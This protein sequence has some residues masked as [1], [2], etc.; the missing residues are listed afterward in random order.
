MDKNAKHAHPQDMGPSTAEAVSEEAA[1]S[2]DVPPRK[3]RDGVPLFNSSVG[4]NLID[5]PVD[6]TSDQ[7]PTEQSAPPT[8]QSITRP[9]S[10]E[11]LPE[12]ILANEQKERQRLIFL[13]NAI[14]LRKRHYA[15]LAGAQK[16]ATYIRQCTDWGHPIDWAPWLQAI[17]H[18][19]PPMDFPK[20]DPSSYQQLEAPGSGLGGLIAKAQSKRASLLSLDG[21]VVARIMG[22]LDYPSLQNLRM[23]AKKFDDVYDEWWEGVCDRVYKQKVHK[24][25]YIT[26]FFVPPGSPE[27]DSEDK[28]R[29]HHYCIDWIVESILPDY[30][31]ARTV[32]DAT[33]VQQSIEIF[34][35]RP[36]HQLLKSGNKS[37]AM[38]NERRIPFHKG[39]ARSRSVIVGDQD[40]YA[41]ISESEESV[42][43]RKS[44]SV[45]TNGKS[46]ADGAK[47]GVFGSV[48]PQITEGETFPFPGL[49]KYVFEKHLGSPRRSRDN[50]LRY[51]KCLSSIE[52]MGLRDATD[53]R[54][55]FQWGMS[56]VAWY[57]KKNRTVYYAVRNEFLK[58]FKTQSGGDVEGQATRE[59]E[60]TEETTISDQQYV[61]RLEWLRPAQ[62][63][64]LVRLVDLKA[65]NL[66]TAMRVR[67]FLGVCEDGVDEVEV[68]EEFLLRRVAQV[69]GA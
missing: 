40:K 54:K 21:D 45:D 62:L 55:A 30:C 52:K 44:R 56:L 18:A 64:E 27:E 6:H 33:T 15:C 37:G 60:G 25:S 13:R 19:Q 38:E 58:H 24:I 11:L 12:E 51:H 16:I 47:Q 10:A 66:I 46:K 8:P 17:S 68:A 32:S 7:N 67:G 63:W 5:L 53:E 57:L 34:Q 29:Q 49:L 26:D 22:N 69:L 35:Q 61:E 43:E 28:L 31:E 4:I 59:G 48:S 2:G 1:Q 36:L 23:T 39:D 9:F 14:E 65:D 42:E 3:I 50:L 20:R 41:A